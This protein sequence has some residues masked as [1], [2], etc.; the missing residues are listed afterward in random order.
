MTKRNRSH[1]GAVL[2]LALS[3]VAVA[4]PYPREQMR[5]LLFPLMTR[6]VDGAFGTVWWSELRIHNRGDQKVPFHQGAYFCGIQQ[7]EDVIR[8]G[9]TRRLEMGARPDGFQGQLAYVDQDLADEISFSYHTW[10]SV[11]GRKRAVS[12]I[13]VVTERD[14]LWEGTAL[15]YVPVTTGTRIN[16]RIYDAEPSSGNHVQLRIYPG[17][18]SPGTGASSPLVDDVLPLHYYGTRV[19]D[20]FWFPE[21]PGYLQFDDLVGRYPQLAA[22]DGIRIEVGPA[23]PQQGLALWFFATTTDNASNAVVHYT[24]NRAGVSTPPSRGVVEP[25]CSDPAPLGGETTRASVVDPD[26]Y[27]VILRDGFDPEGEAKRLA[28]TYRFGLWGVFTLI[29]GFHAFMTAETVALVRCEGSVAGVSF[30][31]TNIPPP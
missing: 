5:I 15:P 14:F 12:E 11:G 6:E 30:A 7:C 2:L 1:F 18:L 9:E 29:P 20:G 8:P 19:D 31:A 25:S 27:I 4:A 16:L 17:E 28:E 13:P 24:P 26:Q 23:G 10:V 3:G 22:H 21:L